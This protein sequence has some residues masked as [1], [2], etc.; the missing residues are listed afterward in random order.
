MHEKPTTIYQRQLRQL[1][2]VTQAINNNFSRSEILEIYVNILKGE[3]YISKFAIL[4]VKNNEL[5]VEAVCNSEDQQI[6]NILKGTLLDQ[7]KNP[8]IYTFRPKTSENPFNIIIPA[9]HKDQILALLL[10]ETKYDNADFLHLPAQIADAPEFLQTLHN[11]V[12][13]ALENKI[14]FK[15]N[16]KQERLRK[17]LELA[18]ELQHMLFPPAWPQNKLGVD[19]AGFHIPFSEVGGDYYDY[20]LVSDT[21]IAFCIADVSGKGISAALLMSNFQANVRALFPFYKDMR[22]LTQ[23]LAENVDRAAHGERFI[24]A[25]IAIYNIQTRKLNYVNAGHNPPILWNAGDVVSLEEGTT[26]LGMITPLPFVNMGEVLIEKNSILVCF[27]DGVTEL[28]N[29]ED[30]YF[31]YEP[32]KKIITAHHKEDAEKV[33]LAFSIEMSRFKGSGFNDDAAILTCKF[34]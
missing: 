5:N 1:L 28:Q 9:H 24:T 22:E 2:S 3:K 32:L 10:V 17:E 7:I 25:F 14:L 13:V 15:E 29:K 33:N 27:T 30:E 23:R 21:E 4:S 19:I 11:I 12:F 26:G 6:D 31:G 18:S 20:F 16:L 34:S 8:D